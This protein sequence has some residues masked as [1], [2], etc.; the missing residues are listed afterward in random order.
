VRE[1]QDV[2][3]TAHA[4]L[5]ARI[6]ALESRVEQQDAALRRVLTL[7]VDWVEGEEHPDLAAVRSAMR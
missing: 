3:A 2:E 1:Q 6:A 5:K 4:D 7:L